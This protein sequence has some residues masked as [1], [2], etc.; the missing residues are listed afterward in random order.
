MNIPS[1]DIKDILEGESILGLVFGINL[2]IGREP[3]KP[4][5]CITIFDYSGRPPQQTLG[6]NIDA[7]NYFYDS[8]QIRI[9]GIDYEKTWAIIQDILISLHG[10]A[11]ETWNGTLYTSIICTSGPAMLEWDDNNRVKFIINFETQRRES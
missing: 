6:T 3:E 9:R 4:N 1:V 7:E 10:R 11:N 8:F 2:F 5:E